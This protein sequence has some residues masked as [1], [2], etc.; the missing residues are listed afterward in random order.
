MGTSEDY[1]AALYQS[2]IAAKYVPEGISPEEHIASRYAPNSQK[3]CRYRTMNI[4][5]IRG[6]S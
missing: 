2:K 3:S 6:F 1:F 5:H 4:N